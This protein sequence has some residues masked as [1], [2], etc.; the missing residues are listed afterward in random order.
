M[1]KLVYILSL[2]IGLI[3]TGCTQWEN[4][5]PLS[6]EAIGSSNPELTVTAPD[7]ITSDVITFTIATKNASHLAFMVVQGTAE[8]D[9]TALLQG[10]YSNANAAEVD[11][12][13]FEQTFNMRGAVPGEVYS[14][15]VVAADSVGVQ[16]TFEKVMGA[17]D[18]ESPY[19]AGDP[20]LTA[21]NNGT[22]ATVTFNEAILRADNMGAIT[23]DVYDADL[24]VILEGTATAV[25]NGNELVVSLPST[26]VFDAVVYVLL[27]F[28]E[29]AVEDLYGNKMA[30]I[31]NYLEDGLPNGPW[32]SYDPDEVIGSDSFFRDGHGYAFVGKIN[33]GNGMQ[34][35][36]GPIMPLTYVESNVAIG[37]V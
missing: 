6:P 34:D 4:V 24:N 23:Y 13:G 26:V 14:I 11:P 7:S 33:L 9:Y 1:K 36:G 27:S 18:V 22:R 31:D 3:M 12:E 25:A 5:E 37:E 16:K 15:F 10:R 28:E 17:F 8:V 21:T 32:W 2:T 35:F 30:A 20:H 19:V 29:G